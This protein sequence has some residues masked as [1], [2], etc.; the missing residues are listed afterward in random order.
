[1]SALQNSFFQVLPQLEDLPRLEMSGEVMELSGVGL[2][3]LV[4]FL[5]KYGDVS[6]LPLVCCHY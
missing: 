6:L 1:M 3:S 5:S 2:T 4:L